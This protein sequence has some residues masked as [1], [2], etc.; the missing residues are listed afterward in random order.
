[1]AQAERTAHDHIMALTE[2]ME[3][4]LRYNPSE[5]FSLWQKKA[6]E[7]L[8]ELLGGPFAK[9]KEDLFVINNTKERDGFAFT[10]F[11]FQSEEGY[12]VPACLVRSKDTEGKTPLCLCLQGHSS[13]MHVS[14]GEQHYERDAVS[15]VHSN[16][17]IQAAKNGMTAI[18]IEQRYMGTRGFPGRPLPACNACTGYDDANQAMSALLIGRTAIG[19]RVWDA[20]AT[21][22][23]AEK[24]F[25]DLYNKDKIMCIGNSGGGTATYYTACMDE[26]VSLAVPS[27][28]VCEYEDSIMSINHCPCNFVPNVRKYFRMGD[29]AG[30]IAPRNLAIVC[31]DVDDIF[32][33]FG[34]E[35]SFSYAKS[36]Y[37]SIGKQDNCRLIVGKGGHRFY[38]D[39]A[40]PVIRQFI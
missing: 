31:G 9:P 35:K 19:E 7:K 12:I 32:P 17:A 33:L 21:L 34:V 36:V 14:L 40:W 6:R 20:M 23:I 4:Q 18:V 39:D 5:D 30:L 3:P 13:G 15:L 11:S 37:E 10:Y 28:G 25:S 22:D 29:L 2:A 38:P 8:G 1:M 24:Y 26:R 16:F 27:C